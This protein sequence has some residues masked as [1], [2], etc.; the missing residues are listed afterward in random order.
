MALFGGVRIPGC[1][2]LSNV[3][4]LD[5]LPVPFIR[6]AHRIGMAVDREHFHSLTSSF[7]AEMDSLREDIVSYIPEDRLEAF[8]ETAS[9]YNE[10]IDN[11]NANSPEQ[12]GVLLFDILGIGRDKKL[13]MT[14]TGDRIKADKKNLEL[15][16]LDHP[17]VPL[18]LRHSELKTLVKNYTVKLPRLAVLHPRGGCCPV[19]ELPHDTDQY[20]V[21]G[22]M[23]LTRAAT[24][25]INH[26]NPNL[27]NVPA[28][29]KDGQ[30]VQAGF[31]APPGKRLIIRDLSQIELRD[32]AHLANCASMI[33]VYEQDG[34]LHT[35]TCWKTGL[36]P[37]GEKPTIAQRMGAKRCNFGIQNGTT[38]KGLFMQL[39]MDLGASSIPIPEWLTERWCK[40]FIIQWLESRPEVQAF[41]E[42]CWYRGRRYRMAWEPFGRVRLLPEFASYHSWIRQAGMRFAQNFPVTSLAAGQLKLGMGKTEWNLE[43]MRRNGV[44][45]WPLLSIHDA[46]MVEADEEDAEDVNEVVGYSMDTCMTDE[47]TGEH[48][49]RTPIKSDGAVVERW[50]K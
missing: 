17:V 13:K 22:E 21:H 15:I 6:S 12:V 48:M 46:E 4:I 23:G 7:S 28:R 11:F 5:R 19:C 29:S 31:V 25:R 33:A 37:V 9:D 39:I 14:K 2:D 35:D 38:E 16:K 49:F 10:T 1:P 8:S 41:F 40:D 30:Q 24:G 42:Q 3:R 26:K 43:R 47:E 45:A 18:I 44:W 27:G 50:V 36:C 20:R 34:D 32:L